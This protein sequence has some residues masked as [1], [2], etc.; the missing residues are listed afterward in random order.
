MATCRLVVSYQRL[1]AHDAVIVPYLGQADV[2]LAR[3]LTRMRRTPL[4]FDPYLS[5]YQTVVRDRALTGS[6]GA[7]GVLVKQLDR[8]A[9][10]AA[11]HVL[12]DTASHGLLYASE[13]GFDP[14][15]GHVVP[16][17]AEANVFPWQPPSTSCDSDVVLFY[18]SM[19]PLHGIETI[20]RAAAEFRM[21]RSIR[22][23]L[24]GTGQE[25]RKARDLS[26]ELEADGVISWIDSVPYAEL[27]DLI[28]GATICLGI[29]GTSDKANAVVPNKVFQ[30]LSVGRPVISGDTPAMREWFTDGKNCLLVPPG[31]SAA[32]AAAIRQLK[33]NPRV[34]SS[35]AMEGHELFEHAFSSARIGELLSEIL[36]RII[37]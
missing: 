10:R 16:V 28:A 14:S 24:V 2:L 21:D 6:G 26:S 7:V 23:K 8:W 18:G 25:Y 31:D 37:G 30:Y 13:L 35:L 17:G 34:Q 29:F 19:I 1:P 12:L 32:L 3:I 36:T 33:G 9:L 27:S 15:K 11:D 22:F 5:L 4:I 20:I